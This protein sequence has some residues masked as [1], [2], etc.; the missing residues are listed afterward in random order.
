[1]FRRKKVNLKLELESTSFAS[2]KFVKLHSWA[3]SMQLDLIIRRY[4]DKAL[5][6]VVTRDKFRVIVNM[7]NII[8]KGDDL[9]D[10]IVKFSRDTEE[11]HKSL[12]DSTVVPKISLLADKMNPITVKYTMGELV[13]NNN[14]KVIVSD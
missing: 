1:M 14:E 9:N 8:L 3:S 11:L 7:A 2:Q 4:H 10:R 12:K 6:I 5:V 13:F